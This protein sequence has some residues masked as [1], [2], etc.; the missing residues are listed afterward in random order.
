MKSSTLVGFLTGSRTNAKLLSAISVLII[1]MLLIGFYAGTLYSSTLRISENG[2]EEGTFA[3]EASYIIYLDGKG[4]AHARDG[5]TGEIKHESTDASKVINAA[6]ESLFEIGGAIFVKEGTY[7]I[8]ET[9]RIPSNLTLI[10]SGFGTKLVLAPDLNINLVEN[11]NRTSGNNNILIANLNLDGNKAENPADEGGLYFLRVRNSTIQNCWIH[12]AAFTGILLE[13]GGGN[14]VQNNFV[15]KNRNAG[16][17]GTHEEFDIVANNVVYSNQGDPYGHGIDYCTGSKHNIIE[18][19]VCFH[20]GQ[21]S[22]GGLALWDGLENTIMGNT[23][24]S[25]YVGLT[26]GIPSF[27]NK[28]RGN[29]IVGNTI[30]NNTRN[31]LHLEGVNNFVSKN[32]FSNN[33]ENGV[34]VNGTDTEN[35]IIEGNRF[36]NNQGW[37]IHITAFSSDTIIKNNVI[38]GNNLIQNQGTNTLIKQN[39]GYATENSGTATIPAGSTTRSVEHGLVS[40]PTHTNLTPADNLQGRSYWFTANGT[41]I[42]FHMSSPD[43]I[44]THAFNWY[45]EV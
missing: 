36:E 18:G 26:V 1:G 43:P 19:N 17:E 14:V 6:I 28:T 34:Y 37:Q 2:F 41:H 9:I 16:I 23:L 24:T 35:N 15:Y 11:S 25:N 5:S 10:G 21:T 4:T 44:R 39:L 22:G 3:T 7:T 45:A 29:T 8:H 40:T 42:T 31:G 20:N 13:Y 32:T 33:E 38:L 27:G 12:D 30:S